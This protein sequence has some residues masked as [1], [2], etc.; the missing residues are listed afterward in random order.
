MKECS[1]RGTDQLDGKEGVFYE[2]CIFCGS[3]KEYNNGVGR[4][5][6]PHN[7]QDKLREASQ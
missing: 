1:H 7:Y 3:I 4:W 5:R 2:W 6:H